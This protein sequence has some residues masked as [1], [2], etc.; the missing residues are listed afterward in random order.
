MNV[1][2]I[3]ACSNFLKNTQ[4]LGGGG[5]GGQW[6]FKKSYGLLPFRMGLN[7]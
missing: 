2:F 7:I 6:T 1:Y 5:G 4:I 3:K